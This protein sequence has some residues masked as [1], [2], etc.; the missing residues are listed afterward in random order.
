MKNTT[1]RSSVGT[2]IR[3]SYDKLVNIKEL[4]FTSNILEVVHSRVDPTKRFVLPL[5][6]PPALVYPLA[7]TSDIPIDQESSRSS[8]R[9]DRGS[10][11]ARKK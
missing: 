7:Q 11:T 10:Q 1:L 6:E 8:I 5:R 4:Q 3:G 9:R 2:Q